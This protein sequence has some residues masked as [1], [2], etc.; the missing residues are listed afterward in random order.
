MSHKIYR[1]LAIYHDINAINL[2]RQF[3]FQVTACSG[4]QVAIKLMRENVFPFDGI[5]IDIH[6]LEQNQYQF[7][8]F[9]KT[10]TNYLPLYVTYDGD[11]DEALRRNLEKVEKYLQGLNYRFRALTTMPTDFF[12]LKDVPIILQRHIRAP[13]T[14]FQVPDE[15]SFLVPS[16]PPFNVFT[17]LQS[18]GP[19]PETHVCYPCWTLQNAFAYL[20][21]E[22]PD[23]QTQFHVPSET[24][25]HVPSLTLV[26]LPNPKYD[27]A[28]VSTELKLGLPETNSNILI[29]KGRPDSQTQFHV[30]SK[31]GV[32]DLN[33]APVS[34]SNIEYNDDVSVELKLGLPENNSNILKR[35]QL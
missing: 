23:L 30:S 21:G 13:Q 33:L 10:H 17:H 3:N 11:Y 22:R 8:Q 28:D 6:L 31:T 34:L 14:H 15:T 2:L 29:M 20:Q 1:F 19:A 32:C 35:L 25:V 5:A 27:D 4:I 24:H 9:L 7:I 18:K 16:C 26:S 12:Q